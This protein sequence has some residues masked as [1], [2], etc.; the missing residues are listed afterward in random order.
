L[1]VAVALLLAFAIA[2]LIVRRVGGLRTLGFI[3]AGA[4]GLLCMHLVLNSVAGINAIAATRD[5]SG[6]LMQSFAGA[7]AGAVYVFLHPAKTAKT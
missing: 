5:I 2:G 7:L 3:L 1:A 6:L 4:F